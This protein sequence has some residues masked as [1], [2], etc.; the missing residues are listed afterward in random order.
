MEASTTT[1]KNTTRPNSK[2]ELQESTS[3]SQPKQQTSK[4][5]RRLQDRQNSTSKKSDSNSTH[6]RKRVVWR[7]TVLRRNPGFEN[8]E[9]EHIA[10]LY[11]AHKRGGF[12]H[13]PQFNEE[14]SP[15]VFE[16]KFLETVAPFDVA[17]I[18]TA[19][20]QKGDD[21]PV[22]FVGAFIRHTIMEPH[23]EWFPWATP[24]NKL[25]AATNFINNFRK[26]FWI[27]LVVDIKHRNFFDHIR[28]LGILWRVGPVFDYPLIEG[29]TGMIY[30][31]QRGRS[32]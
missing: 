16:T 29:N 10:W 9:D 4:S 20:N 26:D 5:E 12:R 28:E 7:S 8:F 27:Q 6:P 14:M 22:G 19:P 21:T 30:H 11:A 32:G 15:E 1:T 24:R 2:A 13:Y 18:L 31:S 23:V 17:W 25:E 3:I